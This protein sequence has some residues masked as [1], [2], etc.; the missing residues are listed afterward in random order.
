MKTA[1]VNLGPIL[2][3]DWRDPYV[4]GDRPMRVWAG[5]IILEPGLVEADW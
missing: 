3:G 5:A 4:L 1:I 2:S